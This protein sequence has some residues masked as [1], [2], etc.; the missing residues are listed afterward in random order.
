MKRYSPGIFETLA[1]SLTVYR[2]AIRSRLLP[3]LA[4]FAAMELA[5][6]VVRLPSVTVVDLT[7][8]ERVF[9]AVLWLTFGVLAVV[10]AIDGTCALCCG[11]RNS[12]SGGIAVS[13]GRALGTTLLYRLAFAAA[14]GVVVVSTL[15]LVRALGAPLAGVGGA[16]FG[17]VVFLVGCGIIAFAA[18]SVWALLRWM[19]SVTMSVLYPFAGPSAMRA[20]ARFVTGRFLRCL[21][22]LVA[23][24]VVSGGIGFLPGAVGFFGAQGAQGVAEPVLGGEVSRAA[25]LFATGL[26]GDFA[27]LFV[28]VSG[29]VFIMRAED[30][31]DIPEADDPRLQRIALPLLLALGVV[32]LA[33]S[34]LV[35]AKTLQA[36]GGA[37]ST[38]GIRGGKTPRVFDLP[39][40]FRFSEVLRE[41]DGAFEIGSPFELRIGSTEYARQLGDAVRP[42]E[43]DSSDEAAFFAKVRLAKPYYGIVTAELTFKGADRRLERVA[44]T[45]GSLHG[46][47]DGLALPDCRDIVSA[48]AA[49]MGGRFCVSVASMSGRE[50]SDAAAEYSVELERRAAKETGAQTRTAVDLA[51]REF[52]VRVGETV[53]R[54]SVR[55]EV[56]VA[57]G[58]GNVLLSVSAQP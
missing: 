15:L 21:A 58:A 13:W 36:H 4:V 56:G 32:A 48:I 45:R 53:V 40:E 1:E 25:L 19:F 44:L 39:R 34:G 51:S 18:I 52:S 26:C 27:A 57:D 35:A 10:I 20:S 6:A 31:G 43:R 8:C 28:C 12:E 42:A 41:K 37:L 46:E 14:F 24:Y 16:A 30:R 49:D 22:F 9:S 47:G 54:Y 2:L 3:L 5:M 33:F 29:L 55:G 7:P 50:R 23:A 17:A 11:R 38:F